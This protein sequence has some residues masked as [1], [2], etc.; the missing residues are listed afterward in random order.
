MDTSGPKQV[1]KPCGLSFRVAT[2]TQRFVSSFVQCPGACA[3]GS[4][5]LPGGSRDESVSFG[6]NAYKTWPTSVSKRVGVVARKVEYHR[7]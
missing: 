6:F 1:I 2:K 5:R 3:Q 7:T 4:G